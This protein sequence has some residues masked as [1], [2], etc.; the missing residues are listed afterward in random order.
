MSVMAMD[1]R[2]KYQSLFLNL[3]A[4]THDAHSA[5][6]VRAMRKQGVSGGIGVVPVMW[7]QV[8]D[9]VG[10]KTLTSSDQDGLIA[11]QT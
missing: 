7:I 4:N 9:P 1:V 2:G 6:R 10:D 8:R 11:P 5:G 3:Q